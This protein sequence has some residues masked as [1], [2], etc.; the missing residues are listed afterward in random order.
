MIQ[1]I[2]SVLGPRSTARIATSARP[3]APAL[4]EPQRRLQH[5]VSLRLLS[6]LTGRG[7]SRD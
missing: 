1:E 3:C 5:A 7:R 6:V 4:P 2:G